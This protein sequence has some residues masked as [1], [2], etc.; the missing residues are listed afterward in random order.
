MRAIAIAAMAAWTVN[1]V[2]RWDDPPVWAIV[3][4]A[5][6]ALYACAKILVEFDR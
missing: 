6:F 1:E 2:Q 3:L 5:A 4:T